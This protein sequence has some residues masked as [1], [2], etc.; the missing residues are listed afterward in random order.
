MH[1]ISFSF[2]PNICKIDNKVEEEERKKEKKRD[3]QI[4]SIIF[5]GGLSWDS[6]AGLLQ[7]VDVVFALV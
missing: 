3:K 6:N 4:G 5:L 7:Y 2:I 1:V